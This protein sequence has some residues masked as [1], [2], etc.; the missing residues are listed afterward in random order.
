MDLGW[1]RNTNTTKFWTVASP[2]GR[3]RALTK[4]PSAA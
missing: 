2:L 1:C 3:A 4:I